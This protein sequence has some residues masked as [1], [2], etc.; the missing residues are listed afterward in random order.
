VEKKIIKKPSDPCVNSCG[1]LGFFC[2][3]MKTNNE[4]LK[5]NNN[6]ISV[7]AEVIDG[8]SINRS[9]YTGKLNERAFNENVDRISRWIYN[10]KEN[11]KCLFWLNFKNNADLFQ[12][13]GKMFHEHKLIQYP[14][15]LEIAYR[16][17]Q[18]NY[19]SVRY[20]EAEDPDC[21]FCTGCY[22]CCSDETGE[23]VAWVGDANQHFSIWR[24]AYLK[25][26]NNESNKPMKMEKA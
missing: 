22:R 14:I 9:L 23:Q 25:E 26:I 24:N 5:M 19:I 7:F 12:D 6:I 11:P 10:Q 3:K 21:F 4:V 16:S 18:L 15:D 17:I 2:Y 1:D 13:L 8:V 20:Y